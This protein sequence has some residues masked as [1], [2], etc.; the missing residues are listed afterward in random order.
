MTCEEVRDLVDVGEPLDINLL[1]AQNRHID[2]CPSCRAEFADVQEVLEI[3]ISLGQKLLDTPPDDL[4]AE[5]RA[6]RRIFLPR[7]GH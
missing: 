1:V 5:E 7:R 4:D 6:V 2:S 3:L